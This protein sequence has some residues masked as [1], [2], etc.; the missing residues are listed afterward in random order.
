MSM[1]WHFDLSA[2]ADRSLYL[3]SLEGTQSI[4]DVVARIEA[5]QNTV[6]SRA[7]RSIPC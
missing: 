7:W 5:F 4:F 1:Y 2:V 3:A 6:A